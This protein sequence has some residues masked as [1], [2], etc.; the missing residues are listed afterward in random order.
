MDTEMNLKAVPGEAAAAV[1]PAPRAKASSRTDARGD[2][3]IVFANGVEYEITG[4]RHVGHARLIA[5]E[6]EEMK[7]QRN[8]AIVKTERLPRGTRLA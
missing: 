2:F 5:R 7:G 3:R 8:G 4:A 1:R 6:A